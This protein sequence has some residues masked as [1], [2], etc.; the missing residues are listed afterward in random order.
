MT[1]P[2]PNHKA[3]IRGITADASISNG[4]SGMGS[5]AHGVSTTPA[6]YLFTQS[7]RAAHREALAINRRLCEREHGHLRLLPPDDVRD[8]FCKCGED[9]TG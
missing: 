8:V 2:T 5:L 3:W 7:K 4:V 9:M 1:L 6:F